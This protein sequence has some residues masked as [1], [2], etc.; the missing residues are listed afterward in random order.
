MEAGGSIDSDSAAVKRGA[1]VVARH[2]PT[3]HVQLGPWSLVPF[4]AAIGTVDRLL[5][6]RLTNTETVKSLRLTP[7]DRRRVKKLVTSSNAFDHGDGRKGTRTPATQF[8]AAYRDVKKLV[9]KDATILSVGSSPDKLAFMLEA[10]DGYDV[11]YLPFSRTLLGSNHTTDFVFPTKERDLVARR[12]RAGLRQAGLRLSELRNPDRKFIVLDMIDRG[13]SLIAL[14]ETMGSCLNVPDLA[15]RT[16]VI[17]LDPWESGAGS[18]RG[19]PK[20]LT[21]HPVAG[22]KFV[23]V[24][25][26]IWSLSKMTRCVPKSMPRKFESMDAI[27]T[28]MCNALRVWVIH[29]V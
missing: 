7:D 21:R 23:K 16:A 27:D 2:R 28:I 22:V 18:D 26:A 1:S 8:R 13:S 19:Y 9:P 29:C 10:R 12:L 17:A 25:R 6:P 11:R 4:L 3:E 20:T 14:L 15:R 24:G 5:G